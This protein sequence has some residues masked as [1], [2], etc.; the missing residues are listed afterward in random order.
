MTS[1]WR[2]WV[3]LLPALLLAGLGTAAGAALTLRMSLHASGTGAG[4]YEPGSFTLAHWMNLLEGHH[5][6]IIA[7]TVVTGLAAAVLSTAVGYL[8]AL[9][10][11]LLAGG[12]L[13]LAIFLILAPRL[14]GVLAAL[15]G[16]QRLLPRGWVGSVLASLGATLLA[17]SLVSV[18]AFAQTA[19]AGITVGL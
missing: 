4:L 8:V 6:G 1:P 11:A 9:A 18:G 17:L 10:A 12:R 2:A 5:R 7:A 14:S 16:L 13:R 3:S 15:F 19:Y